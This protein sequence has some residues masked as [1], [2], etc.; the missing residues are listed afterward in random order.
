MRDRGSA[1]EKAQPR[2]WAKVEEERTEG[3]RMTPKDQRSGYAVPGDGGVMQVT[4]QLVVHIEQ[5]TRR[6]AQPRPTKP[7]SIMAPVRAM[8]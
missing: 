1:A 4:G 5:R 7:S 3:G 8:P 6:A 2:S